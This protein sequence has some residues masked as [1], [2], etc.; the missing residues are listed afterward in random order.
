MWSGTGCATA[1]KCVG[2]S[3]CGAGTRGD[4]LK[5]DCEGSEYEILYSASEA[6]LARIA[7][8]N[9]EYQVGLNQHHPAEL[10]H[11]L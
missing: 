2:S 11:Y 7:A 5:L 4:L 8:I 3:L 9:M 1:S 6:T 10:Q